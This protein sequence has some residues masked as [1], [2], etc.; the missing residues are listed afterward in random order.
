MYLLFMKMAIGNSRKLLVVFYICRKSNLLW[1]S[2]VRHSFTYFYCTEDVESRDNPNWMRKQH[3][4]SAGRRVAESSN[5]NPESWVLNQERVSDPSIGGSW[6][7]KRQSQSEDTHG[8][9]SDVRSTLKGR[10]DIG[11]VMWWGYSLC[12]KESGCRRYWS[13]CR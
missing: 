7:V 5:I 4:A 3:G 12:V 8:S 10:K 9:P 6:K 1:N 11:C 2:C 13:L